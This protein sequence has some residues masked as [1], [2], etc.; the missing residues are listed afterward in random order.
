MNGGNEDT[1]RQYSGE[2]AS[3]TNGA[4]YAAVHGV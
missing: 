1:G 3:R 2:M 4:K